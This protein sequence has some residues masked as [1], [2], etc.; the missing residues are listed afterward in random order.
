MHLHLYFFP[1]TF[2]S[3]NMV[4]LKRNIS[5]ISYKM[6]FLQSLKPRINDKNHNVT[7]LVSGDE[8]VCVYTALL[9]NA[10]VFLSGLLSSSFCCENN[11]IILPASPPSTLDCLLNLLYTGN[12]SG[13]TKYQADQVIKI[14]SYLDISVTIGHADGK[15]NS[16]VLVSSVDEDSDKSN[17]AD[18]T[19]FIKT[20]TST[21]SKHGS[22]NL[23]FP[24]CRSTR[25]KISSSEVQANLTGFSGRVQREYN[26]H[27]IGM[28]MG[29]YDQNKNLELKIQLPGSN[30]NFK[31]YTEFQHDGDVCYNMQLKSYA[32]YKDLEKIDAYRIVS[33]VE[34]GEESDTASEDEDEDRKIYTCQ[35][36]KCKIPCPCP[37]CH[38]DLHQCSEHKIRHESLFDEIKHDIS[39]KSSEQFCS[40]ESFFKNS[41]ILKFS[42]IPLSCKQCR[43]DLLWHHSY[44]FEYHEKCRFCKPSWY[45]HKAKSQKELKS[46]EEEEVQYFKR[47]CPFCDKQFITASHVKKHIEYEHNGAKYSCDFCERMFNSNQAKS[48][49]ERLKHSTTKTSLHCE[50][51]QKMFGSEVSLKAH[52]K[53]VHSDVRRELC[54]HCDKTFKQLKNLR[55]HLANIHDIDQMTES[56]CEDK[57]RSN[58][59]CEDCHSVFTYE[60]N[61]R[62]H[63]KSK[64][65]DT[66]RVYECDICPSKFGNKRTLVNQV[67]MKH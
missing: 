26:D 7:K 47:V 6:S 58:F 22:L 36:G 54:K 42:G 40:N 30:M 11:A 64:H 29:P 20:K 14:A 39:I 62:S 67:K 61:L 8:Q 48:Y 9:S 16:D 21:T 53:Y 27:P 31:E 60:K 55:A 44:H 33:K 13:M 63:K 37:Q 57:E 50:K 5:P 19:L 12:M 45:K 43:K 46:L 51:C 10:S 3:E 28:Y 15:T 35:I 2:Y 17:D 56:Y 49:H 24:K 65:T 25:Q 59:K 18:E 41:Y 4:T 23:S 1:D 66:P 34:Q 38:T 52:L 32:K